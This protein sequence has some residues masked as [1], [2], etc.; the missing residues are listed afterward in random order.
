MFGYIAQAYSCLYTFHLRSASQGNE[1]PKQSATEAIRKR[2][3]RNDMPPIVIFPEGT[4]TNGKYLIPFKTGAFV[5]GVAVQPVIIQYPYKH[6]NLSWET[7]PTHIH[8]YY[9]LI[10]FRN[11]LKVTYLNVYTPSEEEKRNPQLYA[12]NVQKLMSKSS[13]ITQSNSTLQDKLKYH[14]TIL[15]GKLKWT[16]VITQIADIL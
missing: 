15:S 4:T 7:I 10:Q 2:Q 14:K 12:N 8:L 5:E 9:M 16:E 1:G 3:I 13:N 11:H 6:F